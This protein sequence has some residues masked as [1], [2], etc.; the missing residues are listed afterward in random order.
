MVSITDYSS[1]RLPNFARGASY[2][3]HVS[4]VNK[5]IEGSPNIYGLVN[6]DVTYTGVFAVKYGFKHV[7]TKKICVGFKKKDFTEWLNKD[8][9]VACNV[10][11]NQLERVLAKFRE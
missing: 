4:V 6:E 3:F 5:I 2:A 7:P 9:L 11:Q 8:T 10:N 1:M